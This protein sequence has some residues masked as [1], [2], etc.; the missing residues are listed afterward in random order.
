MSDPLRL[1]AALAEIAANYA[2]RRRAGGG[3]LAVVLTI[4]AAITAMAAVIFALVALWAFTL[5]IVGRAGAALIMAGVMLVVSIVALVAHHFMGHSKSG[6]RDASH[7]A[8]KDIEALLASTESF[9]KQHKSTLLVAAFV[10]GLL[11]SE[12][13]R[14]DRGR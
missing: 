2:G 8:S 12:T 14:N 11:A 5:P 9:V 7:G 6:R 3:V 13:K 10:A 1:A 4:V